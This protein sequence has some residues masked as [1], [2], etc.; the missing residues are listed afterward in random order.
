MK[1]NK[2]ELQDAL[3]IVKPGLASKEV[4][5]QSTSFAFINGR[6]VT[7]NDEISISHPV[8]GLEIEGAITAEQLYKLLNKITKEEIDVTIS[9]K[10]VVLEAGRIKAGLV[11]QSE[12]ILP[13]DAINEISKWKK[14]PVNFSEAINFVAPSASTD[15]SNQIL[16]CVHVCK[17]GW[18][19]A[20]DGLCITKYMIDELQYTFLLPANTAM[21]VAKMQPYKIAEGKGWIHF[22]TKEGT[23]LSC[24]ILEQDSFPDTK[25]LF[26]VKGIKLTLPKEIKSI[27]ER[28]AIFAKR[29]SILDEFIEVLL[30]KKKLKIKATSS[31]GWFQEE[32]SFDYKGDEVIFTISPHLLRGVLS[33][34][35]DCTLSKDKMK[36]VGTDWIYVTVLAKNK[37]SSDK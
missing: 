16:T 13:L 24:R 30:T 32:A 10:E 5:D 29:D 23:I 35:L 34:T 19:E 15:M 4:I 36:F 14:L 2:I 28:A 18:I 7:Y 26:N 20:S 25:D 11:L 3:E 31:A 27:L 17:K 6:I 12:I 21:I 22:K 37:K 8:K 1:I 9:E 33:K